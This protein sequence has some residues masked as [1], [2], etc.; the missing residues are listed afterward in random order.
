MERYAPR[1]DALAFTLV[2]MLA[3]FVGLARRRA[4]RGELERAA[5][6]DGL[7]RAARD[8]R[9]RERARL[10]RPDVGAAAHERDATAL[11]F[12]LE[13]VW[14]AFFG[15][16][17]AGDRLGAVGWLGCAV[18]MAGIVL[19]EPAAAAALV[20]L[21]RGRARMTRSSAR[22]RL[23]RALR[24]DDGRAP[25]G[26]ARARR[27]ERRRARDGVA[28]ARGR[29][30]RGGRR[31]H[32]VHGAWPFLLAG[33]LAPGRLADP[34]H[35]R[36]ARGR[37][38]ADVG[39]GRRGAAR[40]RR[41]RARRSSTSRCARRSSSARSRSSPAASLLAAERDRPGHL[42]RAGSSS[43]RARRSLFATRDNIVRG[44]ARAR[45]AR[46]RP[47]RRRC[48]PGTRRRRRSGRG[49]RRRRASCGGSPRPAS[50]RALVRL[51]LRGVLPRAGHASSRRSSRPSRSGASGSRRCS[52]GSTEGVGRRLA[53][54]ALLVVAGG[55]LI[56]A[57][58]SGVS[59]AIDEDDHERDEGGDQAGEARRSRRRS[60]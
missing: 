32:D 49:A 5:R 21:V 39:R 37:R 35:A 44:A 42:R 51:P 41:D 7:G 46:R 4:R 23:G 3:A 53:L 60:R 29:A 31:G 17:L 48:S 20:R 13:P 33:L 47:R 1:Y 9:L 43:R 58:A 45:D 27:R 16:T 10:P 57:T 30:R 11:A 36:G 6:L 14:A 15:F 54:G 19:A 52:S 18:I 2:E 59:S 25:L 12:S 50:L 34:L 26:A 8:R 55:A 40:R 56:G 22:A 24:R 28:G 38:V